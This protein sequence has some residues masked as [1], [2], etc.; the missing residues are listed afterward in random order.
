MKKV[1]FSN[2]LGW[3][4]LLLVLITIVL[5]SILFFGKIVNRYSDDLLEQATNERASLL[6]EINRITML[7]LKD[8]Q[9]LSMTVYY[10]N[11]T[12]AFLDGQDYDS[13]SNS[14]D[15]VLRTLRDTIPHIDSVVLC[16]GKH[17]YH[18]G[19][20]YANLEA[21]RQR[22]EPR[23]MEAEGR[24]VWLPTECMVSG[25]SARTPKVFAL[26]RAL[27]S[28]DGPVGTMYMFCSSDFFRNIMS[29]PVLSEGGSHYYILD[30]SGQIISSDRYETI[31]TA[32]SI[33][34]TPEQCEGKEGF[35][36][37][38][39]EEGTEQIATY[40]VIEGLGWISVIVTD[41]QYLY[42][43]LYELEELSMNFVLFYLLAMALGYGVV[44]VVLLRPL[45][46]LSSGMSHVA[47]GEFLELP[48][49]TVNNEVQQLTNSYNDMV[50][51][52]QRQQEKIRE[53]EKAKNQQ[54]IKVLYMQ[55]GP[56]FLYNTLNSIKW[57]AALNN[58]T[59]IKTMVDSLMKLVGGVTYNKEDNV[60]VRQELE[61][62]SSYVYIQKV[63][64]VN[65]D[66]QYQ[67]PEEMMEL[68]IGRFMLQ[69]FVENSIIHG[70]RGLPY[71][72]IIVIRAYLDDAMHFEI[73]DN[74]RG[75]DPAAPLPTDPVKSEH[76]HVG[77]ENVKERIR[78]NYGD[79]YGVIVESVPGKGTSVHLKLP[80]LH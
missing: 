42:S 51:H 71:E 13:T 41:K 40:S 36:N 3:Q 75:F 21:Y 35:L 6:Q 1:R 15:S 38:R 8:Y 22:Y 29:N 47:Q 53:E 54:R 5:P 33:G 79:A 66:I 20:N 26:A 44:Y 16:F 32:S 2:K 34:F 60:T 11:S 27:N 24:C 25:E 78:L 9:E 57:M 56:H 43:S 14:V 68:Q 73:R 19:R 28:T 72:G 63:R 12:K 48:S 7:Q 65:F 55:I 70:L 59:G 46:R 52:I 58:Q 17:V 62:L 74:G 49:G 18:Y 64:F 76:D 67:V 39:S 23:V 80:I 50:V 4:F 69:P 37:I 10:N 31:G 45:S 30:P 77:I 61:L